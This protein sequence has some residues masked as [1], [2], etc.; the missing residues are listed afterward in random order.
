M[1]W[2]VAV[3]LPAREGFSTGAVGAVGLQVA[4]LAGPNDVIIGAPVEGPTLL[5]G[6]EYRAVRPGLWPPGNRRHR[7][8]AAVLRIVRD[9]APAVVEVHN[10]PE[11][12]LHIARSRPGQHV[13]LVLHN[14][15]HGM[16]GTETPARRANLLRWM[17]V[18]CVSGWVRQRFMEGVPATAGQWVGVSPNGVAIPPSVL[19]MPDRAPQVLFAGRLVETKGADLFVEACARLA[20]A[21]PHWRF[22]M[23][24]GDRFRADAP[25]TPFIAELLPRA[26]RAGIRLE[27][28]RPHADVLAAM[29]RSAIVV[30]PSRWLEPFGLVALEAMAAGAA[31]VAT[32]TGGLPEVVRD[33]GL[34]CPPQTAPELAQTIAR[35]MDD[36]ALRVDLA[37]RGRAQALHF[38]MEHARAC[39]AHMRAEA[40]RR[41]I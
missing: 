12:A 15:P 16:N 27:G 9:I 26:R 34:L 36:P 24:G 22:D 3:V 28:Y 14:D 11:I 2:R 32:S 30:V 31:L 20:P 19:P 40:L 38:G 7:Y 41:R 29:A 21:Y 5:P 33:G 18:A 13:L 10:R 25:L 23:I 35:L 8:A 6:H 37:A 17:N 4:A 1:P 39:R